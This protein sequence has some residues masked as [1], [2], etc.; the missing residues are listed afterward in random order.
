MQGLELQQSPKLLHVHR[1]MK[2]NLPHRSV[3]F[4]TP[5]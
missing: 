1:D 2:P 5:V 4:C 3:D